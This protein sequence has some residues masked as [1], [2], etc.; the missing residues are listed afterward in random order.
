MF[1][2]KATLVSWMLLLSFCSNPVESY[3]ATTAQTRRQQRVRG[4]NGIK[5]EKRY[6]SNDSD[7]NSR[8]AMNNIKK[9]IRIGHRKLMQI[10]SLELPNSRSLSLTDIGGKTFFGEDFWM[11]ED[12][13]PMKVPKQDKRPNPYK[14]K[15]TPPPK[16]APNS[17]SSDSNDMEINNNTNNDETNDSNN[18]NNGDSDS[19]S[20]TSIENVDNSLNEGESHIEA[21]SD[22]PVP[23]GEDLICV[24]ILLEDPITSPEIEAQT[25]NA[26]FSIST[27]VTYR[28]NITSSQEIEN[29]LDGTNIAMA[30]EIAGCAEKSNESDRNKRGLEDELTPIITYVVVEPW[31]NTGFCVENA[32]ERTTKNDNDDF[33]EGLLATTVSCEQPFASSI[34]IQV[35]TLSDEKDSLTS[36]YLLNQITQAFESALKPIFE[37]QPGIIGVE[38]VGINEEVDQEYTIDQSN[39]KSSEDSNRNHRVMIVIFSILAAGCF[40]CIVVVVLTAI[41]RRRQKSL[42]GGYPKFLGAHQ[43]RVAHVPFEDEYPIPAGNYD[44]DDD[45]DKDLV[46]DSTHAI[47]PHEGGRAS[48]FS[49]MPR[50]AYGNGDND[51]E[52]ESY[53]SESSPMAVISCPFEPTPP[54][55]DAPFDEHE[56]PPCD[57]QV[58]SSPTCQYCERRRQSGIPRTSRSFMV[59]S[60]QSTETPKIPMNKMPNDVTAPRFDRLPLSIDAERS[61]R[62]YILEDLVEL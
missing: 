48:K 51:T 43:E 14:Y 19:D 44:D 42:P 54:P 17:P 12:D 45:E 1:P 2:F 26:S 34:R 52:E 28:A 50:P 56:K 15:K 11:F 3:A 20:D 27:N 4:V 31:S 61:R 16:G 8:N 36:E 38:L 47:A 29:L 53:D 10:K 21:E 30:Y 35:Q 9:N 40:M 32:V 37:G 62:N 41:F 55:K 49:S 6:Y 39:S 57:G 22:L 23:D 46:L 13:K 25:R 60:I 24:S 18:S 5:Y 58:C 59:K 33:V 7:G